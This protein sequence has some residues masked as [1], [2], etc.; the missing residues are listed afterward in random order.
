MHPSTTIAAE[1]IALLERFAAQASPPRV[2]AL[3][4]PRPEC[5]DSR[6]GEFCALEL[7]DGTLGLAFVLLEDTFARLTAGEGCAGLAG[8]DALTLARRYAGADGIGRTLGM[9]AINALSRWVFDRVGY[10]APPSTD[11]IGELDPS[12]GDQVGMVGLFRPLLGRCTAAGARVTVIELRPELVGEYDGYSVT[13]DAPELG[14]CNK[15]L[16]TS[17]VLLNGSADRILGHCGHATQLAMIGPGAGCLPD[18]LFARGVTL[19][20][21]HWV[22]DAG[23]VIE[24]LRAGESWSAHARKVAIR[25][26]EYP[27]LAPANTADRN[28]P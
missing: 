12:A 5:I 9:A 15:V 21:G 13:L 24:A 3:H 19:F 25:R 8:A 6:R 26:G 28:D 14:H 1:L 27:G 17:S 23:G 11:S 18:P 7:D 2:R 4:L 20:G 16:C 22:V 10:V